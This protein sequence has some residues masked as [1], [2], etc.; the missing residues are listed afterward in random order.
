MNIIIIKKDNDN[1]TTKKDITIY[2]LNKNYEEWNLLPKKITLPKK[3]KVII[4]KDNKK[5]LNNE[6]Y[7]R[8]NTKDNIKDI[9]ETSSGKE[10]SELIK[11]F[12]NINSA[13]K[14]FYGNPNQRKA[15]ENL[16]TSYGF[17]R[18][19]GVIENTLPRTNVIAYF[20]TITTPIQLRD[21]WAALEAQIIKSKA[22]QSEKSKADI[23]FQ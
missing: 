12:E 22:K 8:H 14:N 21:K 6:T 11:S 19:K 17:D 15:C 9:P 13:C 5:G 10:I 23:A 7:K 20:P 18:V 1:E 2:S 4:K 3:I 16:I